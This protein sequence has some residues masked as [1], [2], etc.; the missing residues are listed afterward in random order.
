M[1]VSLQK[2]KLPQGLVYLWHPAPPNNKL[3]TAVGHIK[4]AMVPL[5]RLDQPTRLAGRF[6]IVH[7]DSITKLPGSECLEGEPLRNAEPSADG[8]F[9]FDPVC[10]GGRLEKHPFREP[11]LWSNYISASRFGEVNAYYHTDKVANYL[12]GLLAELGH[13]S[14]PQVVVRVN[15]HNA[16][17]QHNGC[18]DG[19]LGKKSG[20]WFPLQGGHYR[21][22]TNKRLTVVEHRPLSPDGEIHL[23]PG[24]RLTENGALAQFVEKKY[25]CNASHNAGTIFHEYGHHLTRHTAD[26]RGNRFQAPHRQCNIKTDLDEAYCDYLAATML[27]SPHIWALHHRPEHRRSLNSQKTMLDYD[28]SRH[29]DPHDN[30]TILAATLWDMRQSFVG[31]ARQ[32]S[33]SNSDPVPTET[34][35]VRAADLLVVYSLIL[36]GQL[37]DHP[38]R[39]NGKATR[40]MRRGFDSA[41]AAILEADARL[42]AGRYQSLITSCFEKRNIAFQDCPQRKTCWRFDGSTA[43]QLP[44]TDP[45]IKNIS[46]KDPL[47]IVPPSPELLSGN[48]LDNLLNRRHQT[49]YSLVAVGDVM[50]GS[51]A[52]NRTKEF[53]PDFIFDS[54]APLFRRSSIVLGNQEGPIARDAKKLVRNHSYKVDP[55]HTRVLR[56]AGFNVMTLA[57]NHLLDC[58]R[59]GVRETLNSLRKHGIH[60]IG[61]GTNRQTAHQPAIMRAGSLTVGLLG[62]YWNGRTAA[63]RDVPGSARDTTET[64]TRDLTL[65]RGLVDRVVVTIHWGVPY[66]REPSFEN[67]EKARLMISLGADVIIGHHPHIM[68]GIELIDDRPVIYSVGNFAFG[69][70]NS[71]AESLVVGVQF[72]ADETMVDFFPA[73]VKNRDPRINYQP[74]IMSG[75]SAEQSLNRLRSLSTDGSF[76]EI[77]DGIGRLRQPFNK[78]HFSSVKPASESACVR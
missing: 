64:L 28:Q 33:I 72:K 32:K 17:G 76:I 45:A 43:L 5:L 61:A 6:V 77:E 54:V 19:V 58:G 37:K 71:K 57:N 10:G 62:Y 59:E 53:G 30:G 18:C 46:Q 50:I 34:A 35:A 66:E 3:V 48:Q 63:R 8:D 36:L 22:P 47:A 78:R 11:E 68:Q 21:L 60:A 24:W 15:A 75:I 23:G 44:L 16:I 38:Y 67:R 31:Q 27:N 26:F 13:P 56:R 7:N 55:Q 9:V 73:Y 70:G 74:K 40:K 20:K 29:A 41:F 69:T 51:R 42:Y 2:E 4:K 52:R 49:P 12:D 39:P 65:L 1:N 25:R 14:L